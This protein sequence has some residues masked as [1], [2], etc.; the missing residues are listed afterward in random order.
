MVTATPVARTQPTNA[1]ARQGQAAPQTPFQM[2][3]LRRNRQAFDTGN[4]NPGQNVSAIEIPAAGGFLRWIEMQ[5]TGTVTGNAAAVAYQADGPWSVL[6]YIEF[7]PPSGDPPIVP[8]TGYQLM[9]WN[10]YGFFSQAPPWC[11]PRRD[12]GYFATAGNVATGGSFA[13][14]LR[15]PFEMDPQ[16]GYGSITNSASNKSY[17]LS[18]NIAPT[19]QVYTVAPTSAPIVRVIGTMYYWDE[20]AGQTRGGNPQAT[21]PLDLGSFSQLR[22]DTPP[23]TAGDKFIK[24]NNAG[25]ILRGIITVLRTNA[26]ARVTNLPDI[27]GVWDF[28]F[29]T[30]DRFLIPD[31]LLLSDMAEAYGY[32]AG[33]G[34][35][36]FGIS[37][38]YDVANGLDSGVR[39]F[40]VYFNDYAGIHPMNPRSQ[41]Q[42][43][44]DATL[45]RIRGMSFG[46]GVATMEILTNLVRPRSAAGMF[47]ANRI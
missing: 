13:F 28:E 29:N 33:T 20:P 11:D 23:L 38:S 34:P 1:T 9:L 47:P 37:P 12:I 27:P 24:V 19:N 43:T 10:K 45:L 25:P 17:L 40:S 16:S 30:R 7:M 6:Q 2:A 15:L 26:S 35:G 5:V 36:G 3:S 31:S 14:T 4:L 22:L 18:L 21:T 39:V 8:H 41:Y 42:I 46:T 44:A 32:Q